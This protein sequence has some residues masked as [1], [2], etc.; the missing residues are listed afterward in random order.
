MK[1]I[2]VLCDYNHWVSHDANCRS[3]VHHSSHVCHNYVV[4]H[5]LQMKVVEL[6]DALEATGSYSKAEIADRVKKYREKLMQVWFCLDI[7]L[8]YV[9]TVNYS[10]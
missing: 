2:H 7:I 8:W 1:H 4:L 10:P 3:S 5:T 6:S 9:W